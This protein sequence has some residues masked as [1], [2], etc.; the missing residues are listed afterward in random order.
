MKQVFVDICLNNFELKGGILFNPEYP[1]FVEGR[2]SLFKEA[3][4]SISPRFVLSSLK[5]YRTRM[6]NSMIYQF[7]PDGLMWNI[8]EKYIKNTVPWV[9]KARELKS[10]GVTDVD[11]YTTKEAYIK[12]FTRE[13][14]NGGVKV[15]VKLL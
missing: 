6:G 3:E 1:F 13:L 4:K 5:E 12:S 11:I 14:R 8:L 15:S 9:L 10:N 7:L 2:H